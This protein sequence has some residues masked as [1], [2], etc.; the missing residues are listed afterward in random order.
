MGIVKA[1]L[2]TF[3]TSRIDGDK[4]NVCPSVLEAG[5]ISRQ[6]CEEEKVLLPLLRIKP[7]FRN[8]PACRLVTIATDESPPELLEKT[9]I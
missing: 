4:L 1:Y 3:V 7:L 2:H 6:V 8:R 9:R 5:W